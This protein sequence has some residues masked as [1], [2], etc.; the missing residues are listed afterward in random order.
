MYPPELLRTLDAERIC[1]IKPSALGDVVQSLP[2]LPALRQRFPQAEISWV[3]NR[4][5][6]DLLVGHPELHAVV[7]FERKGGPRSWWQFGR[8]LR[9]ARFDLVFDLQG[10]LRTGAMTWVS[11]ARYRVGLQTAREGSGLTVNLVIPDTSRQVPA[12]ARYW[13]VAEALGVGDVPQHTQIVTSAID[14]EV[15]GGLLKSLTPPIIAVQPGARW[16]TKRWPLASFAALLRRAR[17]HWSASFV[18]L[19][20]A[21]ER[22]E[23]DALEQQL[24]FDRVANLAGRTSLKQLAALF[25]RVQFAISNDSGPLHLAAGM[26]V[27]VLGLFTCTSPILSGP[28]PAAHELVSTNVACAASYRKQC[29]Q[30]GTAHEACLH[31]LSVDR[32]WQG[33]QRLVSRHPD[34]L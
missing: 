11:G 23:T 18:L 3:V 19:G 15:A 12:H 27:P 21:G 22:A 28:P 4:E 24:G 1:V 13:R 31:E 33:L 8:R 20:S 9:A 7:P 16:V 30:R 34:R 29:P 14:D 25:R 17:E 6:Q 32:A 5:L 2:L 10:L 26:G